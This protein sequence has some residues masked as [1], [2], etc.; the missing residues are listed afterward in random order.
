MIERFALPRVD[1]ADVLAE[2]DGQPAAHEPDER[3]AGAD[4]RQL[5]VVANEHELPVGLLDVPEQLR[6]LAGREHPGL[7]HDEH[8]A[9]GE[10]TAASRSF[11]RAATLVLWMPAPSV[12]S[13]AARRATATPRTGY[14]ASCHASRA[15]PSANV[16]PAPAFPATTA[17][18][19]PPRHSVSIRAAGPAKASAVRLR[20]PRRR[21]RPPRPLRIQP[22]RPLGQRAHARAPSAPASN[23]GADP[24]PQE[25]PDRRAGET[26]HRRVASRHPGS[27]PRRASQ[28]IVAGALELVRVSCEPRGSASHSACST[29]PRVNVAAWRVSPSGPAR[30]SIAAC[31]SHVSSTGSPP[32]SSDDQ[33]PTP[34]PQSQAPPPECATPASAFR[35]NVRILRAARRQCGRL[36]GP[37]ARRAP[38][39]ERRVDLGLPP[40]ERA[41]H[42]PRDTCD[43]RDPAPHGSSTR[44]RPCA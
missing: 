3:P 9:V 5:P 28:G 40:A 19:S 41:R 7:I 8:A 2:L 32:R 20:P 30:W 1:L 42:G 4:L 18:P 14:P 21:Q 15:A 11:S 33:I 31:Q 13:L 10:S 25:A 36:G 22:R 27:A 24:R 44:R 37:S 34:A 39:R 26:S 38:L 23:S 17:T 29:S 16:L 12:S 43:L 35:D 6:E